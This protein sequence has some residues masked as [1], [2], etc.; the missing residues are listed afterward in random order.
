[1]PDETDHKII[2]LRKEDRHS[3][4]D[5]R[6]QVNVSPP[7]VKCRTRRFEKEVVTADYRIRIDYSQLDRPSEAFTD[8]ASWEAQ[9]SIRSLRSVTGPRGCTRCSLPRLIRTCLCRYAPKMVT[10]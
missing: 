4:A 5:V 1:M 7:A 2:E 10:T 8:F 6:R 9:R 3:L